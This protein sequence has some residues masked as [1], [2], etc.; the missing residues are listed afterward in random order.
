MRDLDKLRDELARGYQQ[1]GVFIEGFTAAVKVMSDREDFIHAY[2]NPKDTSFKQMVES[3]VTL[4]ESDK[5]KLIDLAKALK[6][7]NPANKGES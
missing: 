1:A 2:Y 7:L 6:A 5:E 4:S 3:F